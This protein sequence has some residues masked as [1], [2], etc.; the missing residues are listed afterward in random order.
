LPAAIKRAIPSAPL[1]I[2]YEAAKKALA[3]C[4]RI[5]E[6]KEIHDRAAAIATYARQAMD[7][8]LLDMANRVQL[9]AL[10]RLGELCEDD[11]KARDTARIEGMTKGKIYQATRIA[12]V[13][14]E[15]F[16]ANIEQSP[17]PTP[18]AYAVSL[19]RFSPTGGNFN[20]GAAAR[21]PDYGHVHFVRMKTALANFK[22]IAEETDRQTVRA[23]K[24][25]EA[26]QIR[27]S[28]LELITWLDEYERHIP[29]TPDSPSQ[30]G[31]SL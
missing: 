20:P 23:M 1:P 26:K 2:N 4:V 31:Q 13:P 28:V 10:R 11:Y 25:S 17:A 9:R 24:F 6:A 8:T 30:S 27:E 19:H 16:E 29:P 15:I 22:R 5:D 12:R 3:E 7:T 21:V 18:S 14:K